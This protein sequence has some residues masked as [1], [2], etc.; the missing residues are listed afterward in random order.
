MDAKVEKSLPG[1]KL[2]AF[3]PSKPPD[4]GRPQHIKPPPPPPRAKK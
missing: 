4:I 3:I 1:S 2:V